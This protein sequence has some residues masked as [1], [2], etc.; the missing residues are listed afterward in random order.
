MNI[1]YHAFKRFG[2]R[3]VLGLGCKLDVCNK[4][5]YSLPFTAPNF[6]S[7]IFNSIKYFYNSAE[8]GVLIHLDDLFKQVHGEIVF[9]P[10]TLIRHEQQ[11]ENSIRNLLLNQLD[12]VFEVLERQL[13]TLHEGLLSNLKK[14]YGPFTT[15]SSETSRYSLFKCFNDTQANNI[16]SAVKGFQSIAQQSTISSSNIDYLA[17]CLEAI[18]INLR[19]SVMEP[20]DSQPINF[21]IFLLQSWLDLNISP[22]KNVVSNISSEICEFF[23][24]H[25]YILGYRQSSKGRKLVPSETSKDAQCFF[26]INQ[27]FLVDEYKVIDRIVNERADLARRRMLKYKST[28]ENVFFGDLY[29][30]YFLDAT[31][32]INPYCNVEK[33]PTE[34]IK[35]VILNRKVLYKET[36]ISLG[37]SSSAISL[38][39]SNAT[40]EVQKLSD[41]DITQYWK[42]I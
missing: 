32:Y 30:F 7:E 26:I 20:N 13:L 19:Q 12:I 14:L 29:S 22:I 34:K 25:P 37:V 39:W 21:C 42:T 11:L 27:H 4:G 35:K 8:N 28:C 3:T 1:F 36:N 41:H 6:H 16:D 23:D 9:K 38:A 33:I 2:K 31:Q 5:D 24:S 40:L 18:Y 10:K 15:I 17:T